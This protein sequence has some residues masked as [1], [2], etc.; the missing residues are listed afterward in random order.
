M[1]T[2]PTIERIQADHLRLKSEPL[3]SSKLS[4]TNSEGVR[5]SLPLYL[6]P[7]TSQRKTLFN[8]VREAAL[9]SKA[10]PQQ[11]RT[12]SGL[13][14]ENA[15]TGTASVEQYLGM[16]L[17]VLRTMI[18]ARGGLPLDLILRL[19]AVAGI[20]YIT[21]AQIKTALTDRKKQIEEF[22]AA[23]PYDESPTN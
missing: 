6:D 13:V 3:N 11:T 16:T 12:V 1:S 2:A 8:A 4:Y 18:F 20:E 17:D 22:I 14:V 21:M 9:T 7:T 23:N 15:S 10:V 19:Q 5:L